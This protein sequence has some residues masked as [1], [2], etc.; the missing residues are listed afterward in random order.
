[1]LGMLRQHSSFTLSIGPSNYAPGHLF[2]EMET[3]IYTKTWRLIFIASLFII[4]QS[5]KLSKYPSKDECLKCGTSIQW[6][7]TQQ[8]KKWTTDNTTW[9][10]LTRLCWIKKVNLKR[11]HTVLSNLYN[12]LE[13]E[14]HRSD[15]QGLGIQGEG[16]GCGY[17][18]V[19]WRNLSGDRTVVYL[20]CG[21]G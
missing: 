20:K 8:C 6:N 2:Q 5:L 10:I 9:K 18:K 3:Y 13:M 14:E 16:G 21:G 19:A 15:C 11:L 1:M 17:K 12:I 7:V 4:A